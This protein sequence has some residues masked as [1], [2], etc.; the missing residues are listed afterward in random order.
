MTTTPIFKTLFS[1]T[2]LL[3]LTSANAQEII[4][5]LTPKA[6]DRPGLGSMS[7]GTTG[8]IANYK[9]LDTELYTSAQVNIYSFNSSQLGHERWGAQFLIDNN[10]E[11]DTQ[12]L[13]PGKL[14]KNQVASF[15]GLDKDGYFHISVDGNNNKDF[16][17]D[18]WHKIEPNTDRNNEWFSF[19]ETVTFEYYDG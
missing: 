16:S 7:T 12:Y 11:I 10:I 19:A 18:P 1:A 14:E 5:P 15:V 13:Y 17:D 9:G 8:N 4:V 3:L 6:G 2:L